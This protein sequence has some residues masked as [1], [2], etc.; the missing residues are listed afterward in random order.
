MLIF[1]FTSFSHQPD[2]DSCSHYIIFN[3]HGVV[4]LKSPFLGL[5]RKQ[6]PGFPH[7]KQHEISFIVHTEEAWSKRCMEP[8]QGHRFTQSAHL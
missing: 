2:L 7:D 8:F 6:K 3:E 1:S 4:T 5:C